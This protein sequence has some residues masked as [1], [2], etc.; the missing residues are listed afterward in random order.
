MNMR[1]R[2][3]VFAAA[4]SVLALCGAASASRLATTA[5]LNAMMRAGFETGSGNFVEWARISTR[6]G[7]Y[8]I[9]YAKRC[10]VTARCGSQTHPT[11][12]FLLHR[13]TT[14]AGSPW[15]V[16]AQAQLRPPYRPEI[17]RLCRAEPRPVRRDLLAAVCRS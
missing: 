9:F 14:A 11:Y 7:R 17:R 4:A 1:R 8:A 5:E 10:A 13:R 12:G 3:T 6:D 15:H 16:L 2:S